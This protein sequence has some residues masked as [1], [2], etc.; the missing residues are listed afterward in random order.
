[1][2]TPEA[3]ARENIDAALREALSAPDF[4]RERL[5]ALPPEKFEDISSADKYVV[6][7]QLY[8]WDREL[9]RH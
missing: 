7:R 8:A 3:A 5:R 9:G 6:S 4:L 2:P 1:M